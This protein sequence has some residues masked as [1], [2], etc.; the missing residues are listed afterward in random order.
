MNE[1][2]E[3]KVK[4]IKE[5]TVIDHIP[6]GKAL[7]VLKILRITG[8]EGY[9]IS[10]LMNVDSKKYGKKDLIKIENR[11][12]KSREISTISLIAPNATINIV[13]NFKVVKKYNVE[14]P[15][16]IFDVIKCANPSCVT[17]GREPVS[18]KFTVIS[19][20]PLLLKCE[21][22]GRYTTEEDVIKQFEELEL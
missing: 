12:L 13:K 11:E 14:T 22:C 16:K 3:L 2:N 19:T 5:G 17:N 10:I 8:R 9:T 20:N 4:K 18:P 21:Y 7:A 1:E 15:Q 6:A